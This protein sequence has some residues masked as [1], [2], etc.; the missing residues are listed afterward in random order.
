MKVDRV[1]ART[2]ADPLRSAQ[3]DEEE[4]RVVNEQLG[5]EWPFFGTQLQHKENEGS[6]HGHNA[7]NTFSQLLWAMKGNRNRLL[8]TMTSPVQILR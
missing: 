6:E 4:R 3:D 8:S 5:Q 2:A 1:I 7:T